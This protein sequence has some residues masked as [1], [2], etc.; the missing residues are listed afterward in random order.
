M[1]VGN[2]PTYWFGLDDTDEREYGCTTHDFDSLVRYMTSAGY[3][4]ED[5]RLVRLWPFAP[6]RTR[7]NAA[8]AAAVTTRDY[9]GLESAMNEWFSNRFA[10]IAPRDAAHSAQPV[11]LLRECKLPESMYW[12]TVQNHVELSDRILEL[13]DHSHRY[14][15]TSAGLGGLI[16]ASAAIAWQ[17]NDD[18]TWE[19]TVWRNKQSG[20]RIVPEKLV[21][22]M[23]E[24]FPSTFLNRD[25]NA[26]RSLIAPRTPCPVLYGI[27]GES[28]QGVLDAHEF[29]QNNGAETSSGHRVHRSN[30][31]T[32]D[33]LIGSESGCIQQIRVRQG[34]HVE[35]DVGKTLL[36]FSEG[37]DLNQLA[38]N[39][40]PGDSIEWWGLT[41]T[42]ESV[43]LER[44]R[45]IRGERNRSRPICKC[46]TR[47]KSQGRGQSLK[48]PKCSS[49]HQ[50]VWCFDIDSSDWKEP[51]PSHRR[52][53]SKP[54]SRMGNPE[55]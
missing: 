44:L 49:F 47:Y 29:L 21:F 22:E 7:G 27:R 23:A 25:P 46:G 31:A 1:T 5:P 10:D 48:C 17:G 4:V 32:D 33:H 53:L 30:Q 52:H 18:C 45:L 12:N 2:T 40:K 9:I 41:N 19:C 16:G 38:Q 14:W 26:E 37:G 6:T 42:D 28:K 51:P 24:K 3:I 13:E 50:N 15:S 11:L 39:L 20:P 34:G 55:V 35:I 54:L 43:H 36:A 8:L